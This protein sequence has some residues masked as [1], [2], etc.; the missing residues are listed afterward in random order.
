M[1]GRRSRVRLDAQM[2]NPTVRVPQPRWLRPLLWLLVATVAP[3]AGQA[4]TGTA[5]DF[6]WRGFLGPFHMVVLHY[7]IG[8][9]TL[10]VLLEVRATLKPYGS[11]R[12]AVGFA[13]PITAA[14]ALMTAA[15]GWM[16]TGHGEF[17]PA[18]LAWHRAA[19]LA[20]AG[21]TLAAWGLHRRFRHRPEAPAFRFGYRGLLGAAFA[22]LA[23]AGHFGGSLTHGTGFLTQNAPPAIRNLFGTPALHP[24]AGTGHTN[25]GSL[26]ASV[27]QP[28]FA[29]KCYPC[30]GPEKQKGK[31]RLDQHEALLAGGSS[32]EA[33]VVPGDVQKSRLIYYLLLPRTNDEAMPPQGKEPLSPE[34]IVAVAQWI[35][36]GAEFN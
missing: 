16:R 5:G 21:L 22:S 29:R 36:S 7:P 1:T 15:L 12:R 3:L 10:T 24:P 6:S 33:A 23:L 17:D 28:A 30:H 11:A 27:V 13:L 2:T 18:L 35:Q 32:G 14:T 4:A 31:F 9:L 8:F 26:Y 20:V 34:E 19:G 25:G